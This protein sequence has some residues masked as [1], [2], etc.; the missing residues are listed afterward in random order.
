M[1]ILYASS[2]LKKLCTSE[3]AAIKK[4]GE[5]C[6]RILFRRISQMK[7]AENLEALTQHAGHFHPLTADRKGQWACRLQ[8]GLRLIF[9]LGADGKMLL[10]EIADPYLTILEIT[11]YHH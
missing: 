4:L 8:G 7:S 1:E 11:D 6:A 3:S 5:R 2:Q 9:V 10:K